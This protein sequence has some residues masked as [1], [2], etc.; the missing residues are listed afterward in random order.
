[1]RSLRILSLTILVMLAAMPLALSARWI[2]LGAVASD[3][4]PEVTLLRSGADGASVAID[5]PGLT[6]E[7]VTTDLGLFARVSITGAGVTTDIGAP[8]LPV[9]RE[10]IEIPQGAVPRLRIV[11]A[12]YAEVSL[13]DLGIFT[14][15]YPA[16][17]PVPKVPGAL[18]SARLVLDDAAYSA[19]GFS[20]SV[21]ASLGEVGQVRAHRFV[22]LNVY[23]VQYDPSTGTVRY[24]RSIEVAVDFEGADWAATRTELARYASPDFDAFASRNLLNADAFSERALIALPIS[25]LIIVHDAFYEEIEMLAGLRHRLGYETTVTKTSQIPGGVTT[26]AI[27][28]Y[29]QNAYD[30]W[31]VPPTFVLL[32]GD[33]P[34]IPCF[35][36][37]ASSSGSDLYYTTMGGTSD[38]LPDIYIGRFSCQT[39]AQ[40]TLM[41]DKTAKYLRFALS[42]GTDWI[43][44]A[45]FMASSDNYT[46]SEGTHNYVISTWMTPAGFTS[47]KRYCQTYSATI[48]QVIADINGG[49]SQLTYSGHGSVTSWADGP[50]MSA[51]QVTALT[52]VDMLPIV[53]SYACL[54]GQF[55][56]ACFGETWT[57][58]PN[59][60]A[61][62][63]GSSTNSYWDE[64]DILES[65]AYDAWFGDNYKWARGMFNQGL[66]DVYTYYSGGG[67]TKSYYEQY[68]LLG[69][70]AFDTWT[71]PPTALVA[72]YQSA[73]PVGGAS[74]PIDVTDAG[75]AP[76]ADALVCLYMDGELYETAYTDANGHADITVS[77]PPT[78]VGTMEVWV[79]KHDYAPHSGSVNVIVP[80]TYDIDPSSV[81]INT[82]T[83]VVVTVWDS[84]SA[85]LPGVVVTIDGWG[86]EAVVDTTDALGEAHLTVLAP[87][88][89][90]L[91]VVARELG[92][93]Y[94]CFADVLPVT[95]GTSFTTA[96][97]A[98]GVPL[99]GLVGSLTP[100]YEGEIEGT[101][102]VTGFDLYAVGCGVDAETNS[103][104]S[105]SVDLLVTP[106]SAGT[107][108]A[109]IG[110]SG[111]N[112]YA[113]DITV[114]VV[115]GTM[116]GEVYEASRAPI[117]GA[118]VK[119]YSAGADTTGA[120]PVFSAVSGVGG[121]Y[122]VTGDLAVGHYDVY[123]S[124]FGYLTGVE[125]V[126]IGYGANDEDF[127]LASAPSGVVSGTVTEVGTGTP[128]TAT[129]KVYRSDTMELYDETTSD[130][131]AGGVYEI[132]LPY[133]GYEV[134]V[135]AYHHI[136][137]SV[138][139]DVNDPTETVDFELD[140]TL[141]NILVLSDGVTKGE[142][143]KVDKT[144]AVLA[145]LAGPA[146]DSK[147]AS[148]L[149]VDL[150]ALGYDVVEETAA[151][152]DPGTW[153][154]YDF[155]VSASGDNTSP[156]ADATYRASLESYV[157][158]GGKLL[159]EGGEVA[160]DAQSYPGYPTFAANVC[161][162]LDWTHDSSGN[163]VPYATT[164]PVLTTPNTIGTIA[165]TYVGYGDEDAG[166]PTAD[167]TAVS[168]WSS[169]MTD[170]GVIVYDDTPHPA[171][172][173]IVFWMFDYLAAGTGR[174][175]LLENTVVYLMA[176][177]TPPDGSISGR[178]CL[179]GEGDHS[180]VT[181]TLTPG[182]DVEYTDAAGEYE[183][184]GL[185]DGTYTVAAT[186]SGW[187]VN[188]VSGVEVSGG[189][190]TTGVDMMLYAVAEYQ[191]CESP[192]VAIP[193]NSTVGVTE[194]LTF[195]ESLVIG[196]V[197]VYVRIKH[198]FVGDLTMTLTS[199]EGT[200]VRLHNRT[201][202]AQTVLLVGTT[203]R[204]R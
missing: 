168:V 91:T 55:E 4:T 177:E 126:F 86:I 57:L 75:R 153:L 49:L 104:G 33:T 129:V 201:A 169:Y 145:T 68:N 161:H 21:A 157:S 112:V 76:V 70:P 31:D 17:P 183:F 198:T 24:L 137:V 116:S 36:G 180:G 63:W 108:H 73:F 182:G 72:D 105:G 83:E 120:T 133:F 132:E 164:H 48:A 25:Y 35:I 156:V 85:L 74:F 27:K 175:D 143:V 93:S 69:D 19:R 167:A 127:Y 71:N 171:S 5:V 42:S 150:V 187:S 1:M 197:E 149:A 100:Y 193:D 101:A 56:S 77:T 179:E 121:A 90:D 60:T 9:I 181:V 14:R 26:T 99:I 141:A 45:T 188:Q 2:D 43:K 151:A 130:A 192:N 61:L 184:E 107:V 51:G 178:V 22:E 124:K 46:V 200:V 139:L 199:P 11:G 30:T 102:D 146:E 44:K 47:N 87:Y 159:L 50:A 13:R 97:I 160:Y 89:E 106:T 64:D 16:Q 128:L 131:G 196:D 65:G 138:G 134:R 95:G 88:G 66:W 117:V 52:N 158:S 170:A 174:V 154:S 96:D 18:E 203:A 194:T 189:L 34:Q 110:K 8:L 109:A 84:E 98:A 62:F 40:V 166:L 144:G 58:A 148:Q 172:G 114:Q 94:N 119:G 10:H 163:L 79:S 135:R 82:S 162:V 23:P 7:D 155:I 92:Q 186:K 190:P 147:S 115:Y 202:A 103:G 165:F 39:E 28:A 136:P 176:F 195:P 38:W 185:Y 123:V 41:A 113:E 80:V 20:P 12:D 3:G 67:R 173:Q 53:Q 122:T 191:H 54:T 81:V 32:V 118:K 140:P 152:S 37:T 125:D 78:T 59:G 111:Y 6:V 204:W 15:L 142:T 29:I